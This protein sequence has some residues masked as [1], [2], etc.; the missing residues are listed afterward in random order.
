MGIPSTA[1]GLIYPSE[2]VLRACSVARSSFYAWLRSRPPLL[3]KRGPKVPI[4]DQ[5]LLAQIP[6]V[7]ASSRFHGEGC[8]KVS[9]WLGVHVGKNRVLRLMRRHHLLAP[10]R[11]RHQRGPIAHDRSIRTALPNQIWGTDGTRFQTEEDGCVWFF[12]AIDHC[13]QDIVGW[14]VT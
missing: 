8:R 9:A 14:H 12:A 4:S 13:V 5:E 6:E 2:M 10:T 1:S 11:A 3:G 7:L